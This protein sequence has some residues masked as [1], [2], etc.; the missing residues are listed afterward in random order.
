MGQ[1]GVTAIRAR[2]CSPAENPS[3]RQLPL[4][5]GGAG[6]GSGNFNEID[7]TGFSERNRIGRLGYCFRYLR[8]GSWEPPQMFSFLLPPPDPMIHPFDETP[9]RSLLTSSFLRLGVLLI[10]LSPVPA[11]CAESAARP[12]VVLILA[13]DLGIGDVN[14]FGKDRCQIETPHFDR[15]AR[16]GMRFTNAHATAS[17]CV[18][19]RIAIMTG[20]YA[21]RFRRG[22]RGGPW[23]FLGRQL[24]KDQFTLARMLKRQG[25]HTGYVGK[26]HLGTTMQTEDGEVQGPDNVDYQKPLLFGAPEL[27]FDESFLLPGSLDMY[28]YAF[29]RNNEWIGDVTARK[30]WSAFNRVGPASEDFDDALV[31]DTFCNQ[32]ERFLRRHHRARPSD[33]FFLYLALTSPHTPL[34]P[35]KAFRGKSK[36]G[37][38]GDFVMETDDCVGRVLRSLDRLKLADNTVVM[39][40][41]D[42]GAAPYAG[43]NRRSTYAQIR[44]LEKLGHYSSGIYRG[45]KF[46]VYEGAFR[47][48]FV[49]RWPEV[50]QAGS[51][52]DRLISLGDTMATLAEIS[53]FELSEH[54]A[55][56]SHSFAPLLA[57]PKADSAR[58]SIILQA[59]R[60]MSIRKEDWKLTFCPGS[61]SEGR[62]G[63]LPMREEAW[64]QA[65]EAHGGKPARREQLFAAPFVQLFHLGADPGETQ[66]LA[67][68]HPEKI[69][70]LKELFVSQVAKGRSTPGPRQANGRENIRPFS[71]VPDWVWQKSQAS[72]PIRVVVWDERQ[73]RQKEA[74]ENYLG[75]AIAEH[76]RS[77]TDWKVT[78][79]TL[80]EA[81]KGIGKATLDQ[82]DVLIWWGHVRQ[83]EIT[84]ADAKP[85]IDRIK[86]GKLDLIALHSA[87][88]STPFMEAMNEVTRQEARRRFSN[89]QGRPVEFEFLDPPG[90]LPPAEDS[91]ITPA[92]SAW[93]RRGIVSR[94]RV[95]LPNCCFPVY[96]ADGKSSVL[97]VQQMQHPIARGLP[98][99]LSIQST[100]M[101]GEP[102]HVP[103]PDEL[104]FTE[105]WESGRWFRSGAV[106]NL[107]D[108]KVFYFRPG[109]ETFPVYK[110]K[111]PLKIIENAVR[112]LGARK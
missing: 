3:P 52:C 17:V 15:L 31:L 95:D 16:E 59:T 6:I 105:T 49:V 93:Q 54:Q 75:N 81:D 61:G 12:N 37:P 79:V 32:A 7:L 42:H 21:W 111:W 43:P 71:G 68:K 33:P 45:Y 74:Y 92:F 57:D 86:A 70:E 60:A 13:D 67:G 108:G 47:V 38:Y 100:E 73:E 97:H 10:G 65:I 22:E 26:W 72:E 102:F 85:I 104:V 39:V 53:G 35:S 101:Y 11:A 62:W 64:E 110:Q 82:C 66:D 80:D 89:D 28:P 9:T 24:P 51:T 14:C 48:P 50:V 103:E 94:V 76:L 4:L 63:N 99:Q 19:S 44:E 109:H 55:V 56:D 40:T 77:R 78:S 112:W 58:E 5:I 27:G 96:R 84:P 98:A 90:R 69:H 2:R 34:S 87:H 18:P 91:L 30:G 83:Q 8:H 23:G 41:S 46:S 1:S 88:W 20:R 36:L 107:G 106:W 25:Y 29:V